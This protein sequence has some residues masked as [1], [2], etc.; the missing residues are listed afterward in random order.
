MDIKEIWSAS[1]S[2][3]QNE[4]NSAVGYNTYIRDITPIAYEGDNFVIGVSNAIYKTMIE[5]RYT[6]IIEK[7]IS[8]ITLE[9]VNLKI[10][11]KD[12]YDQSHKKAE[13]EKKA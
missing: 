12:E 2:Y 8:R 1:L 13:E 6:D 11:L 3:I 7:S 4:I 5:L 9:K 10:V